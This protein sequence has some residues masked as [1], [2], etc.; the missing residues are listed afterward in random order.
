MPY[1]LHPLHV[2]EQKQGEIGTTAA[3]LHNVVEDCNI[4]FEELTWLG[5]DDKAIKSLK[6]L[7]HDNDTDYFEYI[8][9]ISTNPVSTSVKLVDLK[10][11]SDLI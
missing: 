4:T 7:T 3:L 5:F 11:N 9:N 2:A 10:H 8:Q 6:L 1:M